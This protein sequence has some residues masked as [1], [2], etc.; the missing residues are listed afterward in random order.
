MLKPEVIASRIAEFRIV[1]EDSG[2][3]PLIERL[4]KLPAKLRLMGLGIFGYNEKGERLNLGYRGDEKSEAQKAKAESEFEKSTVSDRE[5]IFAAIAPKLAKDIEASW[6]FLKTQPYQ[7]GYSRRSF[8]APKEPQLTKESRLSWLVSLGNALSDYDPKQIELTWLAQWAPHLFSYQQ[9]I[10]APILATAIDRN[11]K[12]GKEVFDILYKSATRDHEIGIMGQHVTSTLLSASRADGWELMEKMLLAAQRQEG[13]RQSIVGNIDLAHPDAC[14]RMLKV[15]LD[16]DLMRFSSVARSVNVWLG[17]LWDSASIK[18]LNEN[19]EKVLKYLSSPAERKKGLSDSSPEN[20]YRT[21]WSHAFFDAPSTIPLAASLQKAK[22]DEIRYVATWILSILGL[23]KATRINS[24]MIDD[25]NLQIAFTACARA[26]G[27]TVSESMSELMMDSDEEDDDSSD[28]AVDKALFD[29]LV[30]LY[31]RTPEKPVLLKPIV[32]PWTERKINREFVATRICNSLGERPPTD[33]LPFFKSMQSW[34]QRH[35]VRQLADQKKWDKLTRSTLFELA[36]HASQ[37]VREVAFEAVAKQKL[38]SGEVEILEGYLTRKSM[39]IR[40]QVT[41]MLLSF[42]DKE[43]LASANRLVHAKDGQQRM[44]GL[45]ILRQMS[46][47]DRL[48]KECKSTAALYRQERKKLSTEEEVQLK[49]IESSDIPVVSLSDGLG[50]L[51]PNRRTPVVLPKK[52]KV[53][54]QSTAT[55][56]I[57]LSLD[58]LIHEHRSETF[59]ARWGKETKEVV[60]GSADSWDFP[61]INSSRPIPPQLKKFPLWDLWESWYKSRPSKL[62]DSDGLELFRARFFIELIECWEFEDEI[63]GWIKNSKNKGIAESI[64]GK[65]DPLKL[66]YPVI[67]GKI[68]EALWDVYP[69]KG[70]I[71]FGLNCIENSLASVDE[72]IMKSV[73]PGESLKFKVHQYDEDF[74]SW[75]DF[76]VFKLWIS[77]FEDVTGNV[78]LSKDQFRRYWQLMWYRDQPVAGA[79]RERIS[80]EMLEEAY[81]Y[82]LVNM[83]DVADHFI[84]ESHEEYSPFSNLSELTALQSARSKKSAFP[85]EWLRLADQ[86]RKRILEVELARGETPTAATKPA[87]ALSTIYEIENLFKILEGLNNSKFKKVSRWRDSSKESRAG[88]L[89]HLLQVC[90]PDPKDAH[91]AFSKRMKQAIADGICDEQRILELAFLAPQWTKFIETFLKW[92]G[93]GEGLYWFIAHMNTGWG[94]QANEAAASAEG[95]E[96]DPDDEEQDDEEDESDD[97]D[98]K[99]PAPRKLSAWERLV[100]ERTPLTEEERSEG[101]VDVAWFQR[102]WEQLG[103]KRWMMMAQGARYAANTVQA[104]K[105]QFLA[106]VLLG[107]VTRKELMDGIEKKKLKEYVRLLGLLPLEMGTKREAD[108]R[109]RYETMV[110]YKKYAKGLSSLSKPGALRAAEIGSQNLARL[111]GFPDPLRLEWAMEAESVKD[112][113]KGPVSVTKEGVTA[114]LRLDEDAKPQLEVMK[115]G[116]ILKSIPAPLKK[117]HAALAELADRSSEL[118]KKASRI[119]QSL[120]AAMCRGDLIS[121]QEIQQLSEHAL[122]APQLNRLIFIGDGIAGYPDKNGKALRNHQGKLE[123]IKKNEMLRIAHPYDLFKLGDWDKWQKDCFQSERVQPFKQVFRELYVLTKQEKGDGAKSSRFAGQQVQPKQASALWG[124]RGWNTQDGIFKVFHDLMLVASVDFTDGTGTGLEIEGWT[125]DTVSFAPRDQFKAMPLSKVDP[126]VFSEVMRDMD[127]V[128]S[129]AHRGEVDPEASASTVE[130]RAS[131]IRET[132][133]MLGLKNVKLKGSHAIISGHYSEYTLHLGS[134]SIQ[135]MPGGSLCVVPVHAQHRG[136]IF[137]PFADDDPRTAEVMSKVLLLA[138]DEEIQDPTI[139]NQL[140]APQHL[141]PA[142]PVAAVTAKVSGKDGKKKKPSDNDSKTATTS[143]GSGARHLEFS[144]GSSNKFWEIEISGNDVTTRWGRIGTDGQSKTKSF[145]NAAAA[146]KE[147]DKLLKEKLGKGYA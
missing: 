77:F 98:E 134:A 61:A 45:E 46:Q 67:V 35:V 143:L 117:K 65:L 96:D 83:D 89:T 100:L 43:T 56:E 116:K 88:T 24:V 38:Q 48:R 72:D 122:L 92:E 97:N 11:D 106:D 64:L 70:F 115:G 71:D 113:A 59:Q 104:K 93:F 110:R 57:L 73:L 127:L 137:L 68:I 126:R 8:R 101:A 39:D 125:V 94:S 145:P 99:E 95:L 82:K 23:P 87:L 142:V 78:K 19:V 123:P 107:K 41:T 86:I 1:E 50:L 21:L 111:A 119:K 69:Q 66:R 108:L 14:I 17:L 18:V 5:K 91:E 37:D 44:G 29:R 130:M 20:V 136:R 7:I 76:S 140:G 63:Q 27:L 121:S 79:K 84:G 25:S 3:D 118:R 133:Q 10:V 124:S 55:R 112:L 128:V 131:L 36:G 75:R 53:V 54:L 12:V 52:Q 40:K 147:Y 47:S 81:Q 15:I 33:L 80:T 146:Q 129:V 4:V 74:D 16:K 9:E 132:C 42:S 103:E 28:E 30:R 138:R 62:K 105:A 58:S 114:T 22:S 120:E 32:W 102:T 13:L 31:E 141:R 135:R 109:E 85:Q 2:S 26:S 90:Y 34:S 51:Q 49:A 144:D 139:L 60:L 6:Q